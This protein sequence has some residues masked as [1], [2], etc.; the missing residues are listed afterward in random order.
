MIIAKIAGGISM[1][2]RKEI[3]TV[4]SI[5]SLGYGLLEM[6]WRGRTHWSMLLT[7]GVCLCSVYRVNSKM[8][9]AHWL[10]KSAL[11][12]WIITGWELVSGCI[13][14]KLLK[15]KVWDYS[16]HRGHLWGQI[17]PFYSFLWFCLSIPLGSLCNIIKRYCHSNS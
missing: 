4:F 8:K 17:C 13:F 3:T 15:L 1:S 2:K 10:K 9:K 6:L 5:G 14:N 11:F 7:G 16:T 12:A